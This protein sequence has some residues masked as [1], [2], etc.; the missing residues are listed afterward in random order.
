MRGIAAVVVASHKSY[1]GG[2]IEFM[3][4]K[5]NETTQSLAASLRVLDRGTL[6]S[7]A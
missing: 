6:A 3:V 5:S 4:E 1:S 7:H 2:I